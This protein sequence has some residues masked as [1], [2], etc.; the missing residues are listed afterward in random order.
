MKKINE[1]RAK[2]NIIKDKLR[3]IEP[4]TEIIQA[5]KTIIAW[6]KK[7]TGNTFGWRAAELNLP[8]SAFNKLRSVGLIREGHKS[9]NY[10]HWWLMEPPEIVEQALNEIDIDKLI[11]KIKV[12][13]IYITDYLH[14]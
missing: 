12:R 9:N 8:I 3:R 6:E 1:V 5:L 11:Q 10:T 2:V 14:I 13:K 7:N 4:D